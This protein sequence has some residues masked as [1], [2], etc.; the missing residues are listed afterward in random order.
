MDF[1]VQ[2]RG[3]SAL[4]YDYAVKTVKVVD[5]DTVDL[6]C[7]MGFYITSMVRFRVLDVDTD[8]S[9]E[10]DWAE[11][12]AFT[13]GWLA[14]RPVLRATTKKADSFGRWLAYIYDP[15][16]REDL[17]TALLAHLAANP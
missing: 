15:T 6:A 10:R 4:R 8:E 2:M 1:A 7:D 16:T 11:D 9:W 5:G 12:T 3:M 14:A 13:K 17:T